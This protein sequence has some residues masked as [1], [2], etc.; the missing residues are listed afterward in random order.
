MRQRLGK[1]DENVRDGAQ[2]R[3]YRPADVGPESIGVGSLP[4]RGMQQTE[5]AWRDLGEQLRPFEKAARSIVECER[6]GAL[7][8][9][10]LA[11]TRD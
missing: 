5:Q 2:A 7:E 4:V 8:A 6:V 1:T 3:G 11:N 9:S 10:H